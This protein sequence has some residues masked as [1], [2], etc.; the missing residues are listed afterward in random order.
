MS[1]YSNIRHQFKK[2]VIRGRCYCFLCGLPILRLVDLSTEHFYPKSKASYSITSQYS[3]LFPAYRIINNIKGD[4]TPCDWF[5][6]REE[7]LQK[8]LKKGKLNHH[9]YIIVKAAIEN[10]PNYIINPCNYCILSQECKNC[11]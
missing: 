6:N 7:L 4:N 1:Y 10:I 3:N 5:Q 8:S 9:N 2:D 11:R